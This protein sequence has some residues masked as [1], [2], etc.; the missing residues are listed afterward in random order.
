MVPADFLSGGVGF[1]LLFGSVATI[2]TRSA[3]RP[4][5]CHPGWCFCVFEAYP[6]VCI[7]LPW[8]YEHFILQWGL[9]PHWCSM[10]SRLDQSK[11]PAWLWTFFSPPH[12]LSWSRLYEVDNDTFL[13]SAG[14]SEFVSDTKA[15]AKLVWTIIL[16][17]QDELHVLLH[18]L[19]FWDRESRFIMY[20]SR[21]ILASV[22]PLHLSSDYLHRARPPTSVWWPRISV[23]FYSYPTPSFISLFR[24]ST[25]PLSYVFFFFLGGSLLS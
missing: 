5:F 7:M 18:P 12:W 15:N 9:R 22:F 1:D 2:R 24:L 21:W 13:P 17:R 20:S 19:S 14:L 23:F 8:S 10:N 25:L 16:S 4:D 3:V 6:A 11:K